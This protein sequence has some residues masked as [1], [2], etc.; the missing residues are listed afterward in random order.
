MSALPQRVHDSVGYTE[1]GLAYGYARGCAMAWQ[2][3]SELR[4]AFCLAP[5][6][7][8]LSGAGHGYDFVDRKRWLWAAL[9]GGPQV[10]GPLASPSFWWLSAMAVVPLTL[11]G[12]AVTT[13]GQKQDTFAVSRVAAV[14]SVGMGVQF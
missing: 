7:G 4:L 1:L 9:A 10:V 13:D 8:S 2:S 3:D 12:F 14:A 11:R 5:M 6:L